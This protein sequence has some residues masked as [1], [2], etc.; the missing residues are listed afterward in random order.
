MRGNS[1]GKKSSKA[2]VDDGRPRSGA[3]VASAAHRNGV[4]LTGCPLGV[5]DAPACCCGLLR[6]APPSSAPGIGPGR[7]GIEWLSRTRGKGTAPHPAFFRYRA[8]DMRRV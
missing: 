6:Y 1:D 4:A 7:K 8:L 2:R 5:R 3:A